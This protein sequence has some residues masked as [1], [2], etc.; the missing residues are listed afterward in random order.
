[1][2]GYE[3]KWRKARASGGGDNCVE[4]AL[5]RDQILVRHSKETDGPAII[6]TAA[7]WNAFLDGVL[8][9]EFTI[10]ALRPSDL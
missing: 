4:V 8:H 6:Y 1:M 3:P 7:E 5:H 10:E 2:S 9:G